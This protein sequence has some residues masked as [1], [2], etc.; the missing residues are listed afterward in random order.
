[1]VIATGFALIVSKTMVFKNKSKSFNK[2]RA[3]HI[4]FKHCFRRLDQQ[5]VDELL[6]VI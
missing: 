3:V 6:A 4:D 2:Y 5:N 1:M